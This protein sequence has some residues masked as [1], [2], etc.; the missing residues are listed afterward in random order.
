MA[1]SKKT[2]IPPSIDDLRHPHYLQQELN[3]EKWR[4]TLL[5]GTEFLRRY[6]IKY[7]KREDDLD[8]QERKKISYV[9]AFAK[10]ALN[11][12]KNAIFQRMGDIVRSNGSTSY[13][14]A[15]KGGDP[16][17]VD[18][19]GS[20]MTGF[21]GREILPELLSMARV[22]VYVDMPLLPGPTM[23]E[24]GT[25]R[26]Y[27]YFY[28]AEDI[29]SWSINHYGDPTDF[30][31]LLLRDSTYDI[32][33][34]WL[35]PY[36]TTIR[37]RYLW[38]NP[39]NGFVMC[40]FFNQGLDQ[41]GRE[42]WNGEDPVQLQIRRIPFV[43]FELSD[44]LL[45]DVADYQIALMN[46]TSTD[47]AYAMKANYPFYTEQVDWR[48]ESPH[49]QQGAVSYVQNT[50]IN[51]GQ[52]TAYVNQDTIKE[53][54]V[55]V[56]GGRQY[57]VGTDRPGFIHPSPE[58]LRVAME[59]EEQMKK[60][61][62]ELVTH[63]LSSLTPSVDSPSAEYDTQTAEA[64]LQYIGMELER[65]ERKI[66]TFWAMYEAEDPATISYPK[67]F[68]LLN[69]EDRRA[70]AEFLKGL[71]PNIPS[72]TF[73]RELAKQIIE[74]T[75]GHRVDPALMKKMFAEID[76]AAVVHGDPKVIASDLEQ[77]LVGL[78]LA[79]EVRG[80][81][82]GE[83]EKAKADHADRLSRIAISQTEGQG[84]AQARGVSDL[85]AEPLAGV[86][87]KT[88]SQKSDAHAKDTGQ[89]PADKTRGG[90]K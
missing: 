76:K 21:L 49:L 71:L 79:S 8:F 84:F 5:G 37:Y 60:E 42:V 32:N 54:R 7:S 4:L 51:P 75:V 34:R 48:T 64:G 29:R 63:A 15:T 2:V 30:Q 6:L 81:P 62:E 88:A 31:A 47:I 10:K 3:W 19:M 58:P 41:D 56:T 45:C 57:P 12:V 61:I 67:N 20:T 22:G 77:G 35:L 46:V 90:G 38:I 27:L 85:G 69:E 17:G 43:I 86:R 66:A 80:Y 26:P 59:K 55:G 65:G 83:V 73:Q 70:H 68:T 28:R 53:M 13:Q 33:R 87:E 40:Q 16:L 39:D 82:P 52:T 14:A 25:S 18:L 74:Y 9:P 36:E 23:A 89:S 11:K 1:Q 78:D 50:L 44:S 72:I 24:K